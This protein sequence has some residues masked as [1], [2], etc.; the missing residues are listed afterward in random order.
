MLTRGHTIHTGYVRNC[1][2]HAGGLRVSYNV[3]QKVDEKEEQYYNWLNEA[4]FRFGKVHSE[5]EKLTLYVDMLSTEINMMDS[6][7]LE[8][9]HLRVLTFESLFHFVESKDKVYGTRLRHI[10]PSVT[11]H[12]QEKSLTH[13][14]SNRTIPQQQRAANL[15]RTLDVNLMNPGKGAEQ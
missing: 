6:H 11:R 2:N 10:T 9:V 13:V 4:I 1:V 7:P 14:G 3:K 15:S 8:T 5:A 12:H